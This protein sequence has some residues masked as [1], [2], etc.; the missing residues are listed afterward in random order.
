MLSMMVE[1]C[2]N[3]NNNNDNNNNNNNNKNKKANN[4][5]T[6]VQHLQMLFIFYT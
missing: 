2:Y 1:T 3:N 4:I 5:N 6:I